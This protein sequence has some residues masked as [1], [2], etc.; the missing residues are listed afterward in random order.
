MFASKLTDE[1][2]NEAD[3]SGIHSVMAE[4]SNPFYS[5]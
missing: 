3:V 2:V 4:F 5:M 1:G